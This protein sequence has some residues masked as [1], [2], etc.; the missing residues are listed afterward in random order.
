MLEEDK[1]ELEDMYKGD[2]ED[3]VFIFYSKVLEYNAKN[4]L[5]L[6]VRGGISTR[7]FLLGVKRTSGHLY[8]VDILDYDSTR[9]TMRDLG[10]DKYWTFTVMDDLEYSSKLNTD[11]RFEIIFIDTSHE[12]DHTISELEEFSR[13]LSPGGCILMH[14][15][16]SYK[17][18]KKAIDFFMIENK[19][20]IFI[21]FNTKH[22]LGMLKRID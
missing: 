6:G 2:I 12:L 10:L 19:E 22:G 20:W 4:V 18:V 17:E 21:E 5:E 1:K 7:A 15:T 3:A 13:F 9:Q 14:D 11:I 8:S 16:I